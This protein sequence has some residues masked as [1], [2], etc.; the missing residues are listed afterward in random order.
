MTT[1][2]YART[3]SPLYP[4]WVPEISKGVA[5][6]LR[7]MARETEIRDRSRQSGR[8]SSRGAGI[9]AKASE[10]AGSKVSRL[11]GFEFP[12]IKDIGKKYTRNIVI[13]PATDLPAL[14]RSYK[15]ASR[16]PKGITAAIL[17]NGSYVAFGERLYDIISLDGRVDFTAD[18]Y[19]EKPSA[20]VYN[21]G[22]IN[23]LLPHLRDVMKLSPLKDRGKL[24][25]VELLVSGKGSVFFH[26]NKSFSD[27]VNNTAYTLLGIMDEIDIPELRRAY[28]RILKLLD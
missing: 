23:D 13:I 6:K 5:D 7:K 26:V 19:V 9:S 18:G 2:M 10:E 27:A 21:L 11:Y 16:H 3:V 20:D 25:F 14:A 4:D 22:N 28:N 24:G 15:R 12:V 8:S 17:F 1:K